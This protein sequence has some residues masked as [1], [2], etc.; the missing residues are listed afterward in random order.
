MKDDIGHSNNL[1]HLKSLQTMANRLRRHSLTSTSKAGSGH[2]SSCFS[3]AELVATLFFHFF[4]YEV[5]NPRNPS[6]DRFVLSKG[7]AAPILWGAWAE[8]GAFPVEKLETLRRFDSDLEGHPTPRNKWVETA[9][10]SLGQGLSIAIG[11]ALAARYNETDNRI[12][13]LI[14]DGESAEGSIWEAAALAS[15]YK[16]DNLIS[17][18][19]INRLGQSQTTMYQHDLKV[20]QQRLNSFGWHTQIIDGHDISEIINSLETSIATQGQPSAIIAH[21]LKGKGVSFMENQDGWH[22]K[23]VP[24]GEQLE[25]ALREIGHSLELESELHLEPPN[26]DFAE[27]IKVLEQKGRRTTPSVVEPP[28]YEADEQVAT[29]QA[30]GTS[31]AKLGKAN[32]SVVA[33][34]ADTKNSTYSQDFLKEHPERFFECFIA[35]QNMVGIA[36]GLSASGMI[37]FA[38]TF[39]AFLTRAY[40]QIRMASISQANLKLC[41]SHAGV[42]I[43]EDGPSQM[44]LE[45][46][47]M[48]RAVSGSTVLYPSDAVCTERLVPLAAQTQ[49]IVYI[50]TSRPKTPILY[51]QEEE[52]VIGGSKVL[53]SSSED[54]AT[55]VAAGI[56]LHEA[57]KAYEELLRDNLKVRVIDLYSI[58]PLDVITLQKAAN[59]T[60]IIITVEDHH[61]EGGLGDAVLSALAGESCKFCQLAVSGLPRSGPSEQLLNAFGI[62]AKHIVKTVKNQLP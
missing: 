19:D 62:N 32:S 46:L 22:G 20:Y 11:M 50:R 56:T 54:K 34:D 26:K 38:S 37:P 58:K 36:G 53:R 49:G 25:Q 42:S 43:G 17:I 5:E 52:F 39:A 29:R 16:L 8:A 15:H 24:N 40:D 51:S 28:A 4:R 33:L 7:H 21:T 10:G 14:G 47:A 35:E 6:N 60:E 2:P 23:P 18:W 41:G 3:C 44:G 12:F 31:L 48:M 30:Y 45:D 27:T 61:P 55:I 57:L 59:E 1:A 13:A 9:T